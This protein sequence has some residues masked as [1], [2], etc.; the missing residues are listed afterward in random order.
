LYGGVVASKEGVNRPVVTGGE[1]GKKKTGLF[2]SARNRND[3]PVAEEKWQGKSQR[4]GKGGSLF[5]KGEPVYQK[6]E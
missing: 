3:S 5:I 6:E 4:R 1:K 2:G